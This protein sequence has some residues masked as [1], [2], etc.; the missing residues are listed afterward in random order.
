[1]LC[2][3]GTR[4]EAIKLAPVLLELRRRAGLVG[5]LGVTAQHRE[6]LDGALATFG[7][8]PEF[9]LDLMRPGQDL[10]Q[11]SAGI[12]TAI[13]APLERLR[14][15]VVLVQGDTTT[16]FMGALA[17]FYLGIP[18]G[19]VEAGLRTDDLR[20]PFPEEAN[21][22][23]TAQLARWHFAPSERA[24]A[25][26][27][28]EGVA[29]ERVHVVGNPAIDA[30]LAVR[31]QGAGALAQSGLSLG[32]ERVVAITLHRRESFGAP[33]RGMLGALAE[34]AQR[35][36]ATRFVFPLHKNPQVA[37]PARE[38]LGEVPNV[39][40]LAPL[41]YPAFVGL[42][43]RAALVLTDSGGIQE[44]APALGTPVLVLRPRTERPE[45][46]AAGGVALAGVEPEGILQAAGALLEDEAALAAMSAPRFPYGEGDA[47]RRIVDALEG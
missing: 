29:P 36:P 2:L 26:L 39:D 24:R 23:L 4:P 34:L 47:A 35:F 10:F 11:V 40:L 17:C 32:E 3:A 28:A 42:L 19:H 33:L 21:R 12:L 43:A 8:E 14:P 18:L 25:A 7:L 15:D 5:L 6:L 20:S 31:E 9:D 46:I 41:P 45:A 1:V 16:V 13:R 22:R 27:L 38:L 44:E 30:A 37:G